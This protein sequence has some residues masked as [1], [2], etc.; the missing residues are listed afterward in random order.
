[1]ANKIGR[2]SENQLLRALHA[3]A[4]A[5]DENWQDDG[6][7]QRLQELKDYLFNLRDHNNPVLAN[8]AQL[9]QKFTDNMTE[10]HFLSI[11]V[12]IER[13]CNFTVEYSG[14]KITARD[15]LVPSG[16]KHSFV[17]ILDQIRSAFNVGAMIRTA[18]CLNVEHV[19]LCGYTATPEHV[20]TKKSCMGADEFV[21]WSWKKTSLDAIKE[22]RALGYQVVALETV[23]DARN[24]VS[25]PFSGKVAIVCGNERY[26]LDAKILKCCDSI[27]Q[28]PVF[29]HKNSLNVAT[30]LA[31]AAYSCL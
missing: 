12:P 17:F 25:Q 11:L 4:L 9:A 18:D 6:H 26:G 16:E 7:R 21:K 5:I 8:L 29:G 14:L 24:I 2:E 13:A 27:A 23:E 20:K 15:S 31:I 22:V 19:Y 28:I 10:R 30:A 1:M 3:L